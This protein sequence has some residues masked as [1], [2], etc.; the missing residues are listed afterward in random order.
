MKK[1]LACLAALLLAGANA[2]ACDQPQ[3]SFS[4]YQ[5]QSYAPM[6][7]VQQTYSVPFAQY[8]MAVPTAQ[9]FALQPPSFTIINNNNNN[10]AGGRVGVGMGTMTLVQP[11]VTSGVNVQTNTFVGRRAFRFAR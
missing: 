4:L 7:Y 2:Q 1:Y 11:G 8:R 9:V 10:N 6:G 5:Q 3:A